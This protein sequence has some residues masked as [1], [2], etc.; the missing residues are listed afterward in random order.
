MHRTSDGESGVDFIEPVS[1]PLQAEITN[2]QLLRHPVV[3]QTRPM[4]GCHTAIASG[5]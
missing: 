2:Q 5:T 3:D 4:E 1:T